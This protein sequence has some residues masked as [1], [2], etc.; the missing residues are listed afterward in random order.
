MEEADG[1]VGE[2]VVFNTFGS[3][4]LNQPYQFTSVASFTLPPSPVT[5]KSPVDVVNTY[6]VTFEVLPT[7]G[8]ANDY[9]AARVAGMEIGE[10]AEIAPAA[11][12]EAEG[13]FGPVQ[14]TETSEPLTAAE[15]PED[16][17]AF[18][19][20]VSGRGDEGEEAPPDTG[21]GGEDR[22][23]PEPEPG[24]EPEPEPEPVMYGTE[25]DD[26]LSGGQ[27]DDTIYG[28][29]GNDELSGDK[30]KDTLYGGEG[31]DVLTGGEG[32]D[33]FIFGMDDD[34]DTVTDFS[35]GDVLRFEGDDFVESVVGFDQDGDD[36]IV[37]F[38]ASDVEVVLNNTDSEQ[39]GYT[40]TPES[41]AVIVA[42]DLPPDG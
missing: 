40:V 42:L 39:L 25:G 33:T 32:E 8:N 38:S 9:G 5:T 28:L 30:G 19:E 27:G 18:M 23:D 26:V 6:D 34:A 14:V 1:F 7:G 29:G 13:G 10:L 41:D 37:S 2:V 4:V 22:V 31:D 16:L 20:E 11:S 17:F 15:P 35:Q 36:A 21:G 24:P 3:I 12:D